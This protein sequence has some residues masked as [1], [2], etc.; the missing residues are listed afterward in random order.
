M[1]IQTAFL[2]D[3]L[4][5]TPFFKVLRRLRPHDKITLLCRKGL[6]DFIIK[7]GLVDEAIEADKSSKES[8]AK[9]V[10]Q[11]KARRFD[12]L[13]CPHESFRSLKL[14]AELQAERKIGYRHFLNFF[15][16]DDRLRRPLELPEALR[17]LALLAPIDTLPGGHLA[18]KLRNFSQA[19]G[20]NGGQVNASGKLMPVPE[21]ADMRIPKLEAVRNAYKRDRSLELLSSPRV[22]AVAEKILSTG[23]KLSFLAPGSVWPTKMWTHEGYA[24]VARVLQ[25]KGY[26]V[27][28]LGA[29]DEKLICERILA[30]APG[31]ISIAGETSLFE[32]A[33]LLALAEFLVCNDSG[34]MH[35]AATAGVPLVSIFGPTVLEFGYR[36]W[37][38]QARVVQIPR[39]QMPC[40]PCGKHGAKA[41]PLGHHRCMKDVS[42]ET[43]LNELDSLKF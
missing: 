12:L 19:Q 7:A 38:T 22:R 14:A 11:L 23:R 17:Q 34:A 40:R 1:I 32:S 36:P 30:E 10:T 35:L 4:L 18:D 21:W 3:L 33:E 39:E 8:W 27:V 29:P 2:G 42:A 24:Q 43:V 5:G 31:A 6:A 20:A 37:E 15:V 13:F 28:L 26:Q 16:F 41:C 9:A 25:S